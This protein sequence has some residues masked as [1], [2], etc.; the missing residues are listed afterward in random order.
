[1]A[2][3]TASHLLEHFSGRLLTKLCLYI[4][5]GSVRADRLLFRGQGCYASSYPTG[6][7]ISALAVCSSRAHSGVPA[8]QLPWNR[9]EVLSG[10]D[11]IRILLFEGQHCFLA[12][13][14]VI[15]R[16]VDIP[17]SMLVIVL[18]L[19][20]GREEGCFPGI[21]LTIQHC[22][23]RI[24]ENIYLEILLKNRIQLIRSHVR[25]NLPKGVSTLK[26]KIS[27]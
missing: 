13:K 2:S 10:S 21:G 20:A 14:N 11:S 26:K 25:L 23:L 4:L 8:M 27:K 24:K 1:M 16:H 6:A 9:K 5:G 19:K 7:L 15:D 12:L 18:C 22:L 3:V 17:V